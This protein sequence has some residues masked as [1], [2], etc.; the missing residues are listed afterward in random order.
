VKGKKQAEREKG[1]SVTPGVSPAQT[2]IPAAPQSGTPETSTSPPTKEKKPSGFSMLLLH[3]H[4]RMVPEEA[5]QFRRTCGLGGMAVVLLVLLAA[6]GALL[7]L[8][9]EPSAERAYG[10][11]Q[12][13]RDDTAFGG[14]V[15]NIHFWAAN[16]LVLVAILHLLRVFYT[17]AFHAPR[18]FNWIIGLL[19]L[20]LVLG[21]NFTGYLLPWDQLAF[22]AVTIGT[23]MLEYVP[24][25]GPTLEAALRG[26]G[27]VGAKTLSIFFV[28]HIA[29]LPILGAILAAFHFWLVRKGGGVI[30]SRPPGQGPMPK[31]TMVPTSPNL[32]LRELV[33]ALTLIA[34]VL[35][36]AAIFDAPLLAQANPG[37]SPNPAKAPWYFMGVQELLV[38]LHPV[39]AI[40]WVPLVV[41]AFLVFLPYVNYGEAPSGRWFH[42]ANGQRTALVAAVVALVAV[43]VATL[44]NEYVVSLPKLLPSLPP[45]ASTGVLPAGTLVLG[46]LGF[47]GLIKRR[48]AGSRIESVQAVFTLLAVGFVLLTVTGVFFRGTAMRL[49]WPWLTK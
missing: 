12:S 41:V 42:S 4:P 16:S 20:G 44:A 1:R 22:W 29:I 21:S 13:L 34:G 49:M 10:S 9:Y 31:P 30:L 8:A 40:L 37:M 36:A 3:V 5:L 38:H 15:R 19:L 14:F 39:F 23:G 43:P 11:V 7:L 45:I 18:R 47:F 6:T 35:L 32:V 27:E 28:L 2:K 48:F 17:G 24:L 25:I 33:V 46:V 26:G